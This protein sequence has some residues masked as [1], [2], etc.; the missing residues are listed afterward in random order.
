M[1]TTESA[2]RASAGHRIGAFAVDA[3]LYIVTLGI[4]WFIWSMVLWNQGQTPAKKLLKLRVLD[5]TTGRPARWGHMLI[6]QGLIP[7]TMSLGFYVPY[8]T[9]ILSGLLLKS[10]AIAIVG[11][12]L[13]FALVLT[14]HIVDF[15]WLFGK[16]GK[17]L[18][19]YWA[20]TIVVN[21]AIS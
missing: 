14:I 9:S 4:G 1:E 11:A 16:S 21:E 19:D 10:T 3:G 5:E 6:R 2:V 12:I 17:R 13:S 7:T 15:V 18:V 8:L 20:K